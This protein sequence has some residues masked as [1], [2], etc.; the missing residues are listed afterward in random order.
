MKKWLA[1]DGFLSHASTLGADLSYLLAVVF[2][3]LFLIAWILAKKNRGKLHHDLIFVSM[4]T[5]VV[6]FTVYYL[7]RQ[8]GVLALEGKEGFGGPEKIYHNVFVPILTIH[9]FLVTIGLIMAF[10]MIIEGFRASEKTKNGYVL[11]QGD[12][13][14]EP[15]TF[16]KAM[17]IFLGLWFLNQ[18]ALTFIRHAS[19]QSSLAWAIIF[20]TLAVVV[21]LEKSVEKFI[22]DGAKRHRLL[23]RGTMVIYILILCTSTAT[24]LMLYVFY[25]A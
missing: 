18:I 24:Y 2:T 19:W 15:K 16:K 1:Q 9:L 10:Y 22:P 20:A 21:S 25:P 7:L 6:Y 4:V 11:K 3:V 13:K 8:L 5:M 17:L 23:G 12:L 14:M